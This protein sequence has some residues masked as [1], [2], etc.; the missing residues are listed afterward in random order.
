MPG[1]ALSQRTPYSHHPPSSAPQFEAWGLP[2][3]GVNLGHGSGTPARKLLFSEA[4]GGCMGR[5]TVGSQRPGCFSFFPP[6]PRP[7]RPALRISANPGPSE[8]KTH[9]P[10]RLR[11]HNAGPRPWAIAQGPAPALQTSPRIITSKFQVPPLSTRPSSSSAL[12]SAPRPREKPSPVPGV[13]GRR[14]VVHP[15]GSQSLL[16][17]REAW[18]WE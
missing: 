7:P 4:S 6:Q 3:S 8:H 10:L 14:C 16:V 11:S 9:P 1:E 18:G 17:G 12:P 15:R 2:E 13:G 5:G